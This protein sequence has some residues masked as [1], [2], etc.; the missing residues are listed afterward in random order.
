MRQR[1]LFS[2]QDVSILLERTGLAKRIGTNSIGNNQTKLKRLRSFL[3]REGVQLARSVQDDSRPKGYPAHHLRWMRFLGQVEKLSS[4]LLKLLRETESNPHKYTYVTDTQLLGFK[5]DETLCVLENL[6]SE[7]QSIAKDS[8]YSLPRGA[9]KI[10]WL[11]YFVCG[12]ALEYQALTGRPF[13]FMR[14]RDDSGMYSPITPGHRL[15]CAVIDHLSSTLARPIQSSAI[16]TAAERA[17]SRIKK[18]GLRET[19]RKS[20]RL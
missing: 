2:N 12:L 6:H 7:V 14:H 16:A 11:E 10:V 4:T 3:N 17:V 20:T 19:P 9:P 13:T 1:E 5:L 15:V 18:A 8:D